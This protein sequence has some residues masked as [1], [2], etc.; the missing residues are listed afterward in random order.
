[1]S[2]Q[3]ECVQTKVG[4][5]GK[6]SRGAAPVRQNAKASTAGGYVCGG[7]ETAPYRPLRTP[8]TT[9][10]TRDSQTATRTTTTRTT[11][12]GWCPSGGSREARLHLKN[13]YTYQDVFKA[14]IDCRRSKR[15]SRSA[16]AFETRFEERLHDLLCELNDGTYEVSRSEVFVVEH[17]KPREIWAAQF[18]DRIVHHL[19]F[20]DI[21]KYFEA[22]FI[23]DTFSCI[24]GRGTLAASN[25]LTEMHRRAT[26]NYSKDCWYLQFDIK[27]FFVSINKDILWSQ[28]EREIGADS[29]TARLTK[30]VIYNDPTESP[31]IKPNSRFWLV[32]THKS[33]W[34]SG[35]NR[36]LPIGNLTSQFFSNVYMD[37]FDK[38][39]KHTLKARHYVRYVDDA[40]IL[41]SDRAELEWM[42]EQIRVFLR[43]RL[44]IE[45]HP[46]KWAIKRAS[47]G[48][49]FVGY[50]VKPYRRYTRRS[51]VEAAKRAARSGS[52]ESINSYLGLMRH[53][54]SHRIRRAICETASIPSIVMPGSGFSKVIAL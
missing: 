5:A 16:I 44:A 29:L 53:S 22:R 3:P 30:Q 19:I 41:G 10:G 7:L 2:L 4:A 51:T 34:H 6:L 33:L 50:I 31:V 17:P 43:D 12:S 13:S 54:A 20:N 18:R 36:G 45:I 28:L 23:E 49:N 47:Q 8:A 14:Y 48:I 26:N 46:E 35:K 38:F 40:V 24:K 32:P 39:V 37:D 9:A 11:S 27:N 42:L 15:N 25:R 52:V 1:M 21:G